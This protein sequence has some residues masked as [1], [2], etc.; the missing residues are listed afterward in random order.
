MILVHTQEA[1]AIETPNGNFGT[2]LAT[3]SRGASDVSVVRQRQVPG[4]YN[5]LHT[6]DREE[7]MIQLAGTVTVTGGDTRHLLLP[8][9]TLIIPARTAHRVDNTGQSD[10]EWLIISTA[11]VRFF[12]EN[13]EEASPPWVQ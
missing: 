1:D 7:V 6:H 13:G 10:A 4:G 2:G 12:R 9:D 5:P 8:G 3:P 11:G